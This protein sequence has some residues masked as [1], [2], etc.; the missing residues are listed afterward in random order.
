MLA[1]LK[2][3]VLSN[4]TL[5]MKKTDFNPH[6]RKNNDKSSN[7]ISVPVYSILIDHSDGMILFDTGCH[8]D[9]MGPKGRWPDSLQNE[10]PWTASE[11][12]HLWNQ[13]D[14]LNIRP[15]DIRYVVASHLHCDHAGNLAMFPN[16][17]I[18]VHQNELQ[19]AKE[20]FAAGR[21]DGEFVKADVSDWRAISHWQ[22]INNNI[23]STK[24]ASD[25]RI[26]NLGRGHSYGMLGLEV[27][28][29]ETGPLFL[30]SDAAYSS[31]NYGPEG[32][33][34]KFVIDGNGYKRGT[35]QIEQIIA[36]SNAQVWYGHDVKQFQSLIKSTEGWY[37]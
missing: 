26:H 7:Y 30:A 37:E 16:A 22:T 11:S 32:V 31:C 24:L 34:P 1:P 21:D 6:Y 25:L 4:G 15:A 27:N 18:I 35:Q 33:I 5:R 13:L 20:A 3:F 10:T 2:L 12:E 29:A 8:P 28:L 23:T 14:Q 9:S 19:A 36:K 17:T